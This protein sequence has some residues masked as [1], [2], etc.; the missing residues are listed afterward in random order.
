[1]LRCWFS[2]IVRDYSVR[3]GDEVR[4]RCGNLI[5][6]VDGRKVIMKQ[7][8]FEYSGTKTRK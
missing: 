6:I 1:V 3:E 4:C 2:R 7:N 5:G 8:A